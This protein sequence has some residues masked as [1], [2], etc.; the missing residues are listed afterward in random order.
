VTLPNKKSASSAASGWSCESVVEP[1]STSGPLAPGQ[2]AVITSSARKYAWV[3]ERFMIASSGTRG[4]ARDWW[5]RSIHVDGRELL[6]KPGISGKYFAT[7]AVWSDVCWRIRPG[8]RIVMVVAY[9]GK[10]RRG[11]PFIA[12]FIGMRARAPKTQRTR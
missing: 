4:G 11:C 6:K 1:M 9:V 10:K 3:A 2:V 12:A 5:L 7:N 8:C